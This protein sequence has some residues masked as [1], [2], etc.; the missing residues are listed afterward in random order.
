MVWNIYYFHPYLGQ[1]PI[2]TNIFQMGWNHQLFLY[3]P[4]G[5]AR[6]S[7]PSI[8]VCS[9]AMWPV[10]HRS[11]VLGIENPR[12][13]GH[14][15]SSPWS[16]E[17]FMKFNHGVGWFLHDFYWDRKMLGRFSGLHCKNLVDDFCCRMSVNKKCMTPCLKLDELCWKFAEALPDWKWLGGPRALSM[18]TVMGP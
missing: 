9:S 12:R 15:G 14:S 16:D 2:L 11:Q 7:E 10:T 1:N 4:A 3:I 18:E 13:Q 8:N 5:V 17:V 6:I